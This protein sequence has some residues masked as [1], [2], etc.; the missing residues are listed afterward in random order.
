L[1]GR[2]GVTGVPVGTGASNASLWVNPAGTTANHYLFSVSDDNS[3]RFSVDKEGDVTVG[4]TLAV[5]AFATFG[6]GFT[7]NSYSTINNGS[8]NPSLTIGATG[9]ARALSISANT[10]DSA[11]YITNTNSG[12]ALRIESSSGTNAAVH[13]TKANGIDGHV[14]SALSQH[15]GS[16]AAIRGIMGWSPNTGY[17]VYG[18]NASGTGWAGYFAGRLGVVGNVAITGN[19]NVT[20]TTT[21]ASNSIADSSLSTNVMLRDATQSVSGAKTFTANTTIDV[22]NWSSGLYFASQGSLN[23]RDVSATAGDQPAYFGTA[24]NGL[25]IYEAT[26]GAN[27]ITYWDVDNNRVGINNSSPSYGL[28]VTGTGRFTST[29]LVGSTLTVSTGGLTVSA[30]GASISGTTTINTAAAAGATTIGNTSNTLTLNSSS[31]TVNG[32]TTFANNLTVSSGRLTVTSGTN[33]H[34]SF[35]T[36]GS[37]VLTTNGAKVFLAD[38]GTANAYDAGDAIIGLGA[39]NGIWYDTGNSGVTSGIH[40]FY[41]WGTERMRIDTSGVLLMNGG[42]Y[43]FNT[44]SERTYMVHPFDFVATHET[45]DYSITAT[46]LQSSGIMYAPF[47]IPYPSYTITG[48]DC[49]YLDNGA[50]FVSMTV[51]RMTNDVGFSV[52]PSSSNIATFTSSVAGVNATP[53]VW[54]PAVTATLIRPNWGEKAGML[55]WIG[56]QDTSHRFYGCKIT[57]TIPAL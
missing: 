28:D 30:G 55:V 15:G 31:M 3:V 29:L 47:Q 8:A 38:T 27:Y 39:N 52:S 49:L 48:V 46:Y 34:L 54:T 1:R 23:F 4:S 43:R 21:F 51:Y 50:S 41:T 25:W 33:G 10:T 7:S 36:A 40:N 9:G 2:I 35:G 42:S 20:G 57:Y 44:A 45:V 11:V 22:N 53:Q 12:T 56:S 14:I 37:G 24:T 16:G 17:G 5:S 19:L 32:N 26:G 6:T 18:E 13:V